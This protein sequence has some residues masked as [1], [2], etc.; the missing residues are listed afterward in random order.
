VAL[1]GRT[2]AAPSFSDFA[3]CNAAFKKYT[4]LQCWMVAHPGHA[5]TPPTVPVASVN[6]QKDYQCWNKGLPLPNFGN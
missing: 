3:T 5:A 1:G 2:Q 6:Q 4:D